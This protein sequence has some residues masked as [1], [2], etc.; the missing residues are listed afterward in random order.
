M[1]LVLAAFGSGQSPSTH[2]GIYGVGTL[3]NTSKLA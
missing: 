3:Y 2:R 1:K